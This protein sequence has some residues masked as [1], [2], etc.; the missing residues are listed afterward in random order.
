MERRDFLMGSSVLGAMAL[1]GTAVAAA[2]RSRANDASLK[3][4]VLDLTTPRGNR[5][6]GPGCWATRT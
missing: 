5:E 6:A 3:G 2:V 1:G 4:P